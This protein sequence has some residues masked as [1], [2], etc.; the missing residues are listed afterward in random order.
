MLYRFT[1]ETNHND[2]VA[3]TE[4]VQ[5]AVEESRVTSGICVV[6]PPHTTAGLTV[7][8]FWDPKGYEDI[9]DETCRLVPTR[10]DFK[11]QHDTPQDAAG[12]VKSSLIGISLTFIIDQ[13][14]L[15]LGHSQ[16][17]FFMEFDGPRKREYFV[18]I[19]AEAK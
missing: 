1:L 14:K 5:N 19:I 6:Y 9:M 7:T 4:T 13:G 3:L 12:H 16:G 18:K 10:I 15:F 2:F 17:I 11:H 8:S